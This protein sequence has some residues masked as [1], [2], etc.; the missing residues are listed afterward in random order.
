MWNKVVGAILNWLMNVIVLPI[1][2]VVID[3]FHM[4]KVIK[5][6]K[7]EVEALKKAQTAKEKDEAID[8]MP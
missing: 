5:E 8:R 2:Y 3:Y 7:A 1:S 4:K 6:T